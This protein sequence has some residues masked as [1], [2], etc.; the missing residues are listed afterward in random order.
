MAQQP[1]AAIAPYGQ[2]Q[3]RASLNTPQ[4]MRSRLRA[5]GQSRLFNA[6]ARRTRGSRSKPTRTSHRVVA[7][8]AAAQ[9]CAAAAA[10][11]T[12]SRNISAA[13]CA[14]A[15]RRASGTAGL[16]PRR[17]TATPRR[18]GRAAL[19]ARYRRQAAHRGVRPGRHHQH[20]HRRCRRQCQSAAGRHVPARGFT[21]Q[22]LSQSDHRAAQARLRARA[23]RQ[24]SRSRPT[25]RSSFSAKSPTPGQYPYVANMTAETAVAI[26]GGFAPRADK[27][28]VEAHPQRARPADARR[29]AA[30]LL[31]CAPATPSS[32]R[33]AGS[34]ASSSVQKSGGAEPSPDILATRREFRARGCRS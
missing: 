8:R 4:A 24:R 17:R 19:H 13:I 15:I 3:Y 26:A 21:T 32:S 23:A 16:T 22:Q 5:V 10:A 6:A 12:R 7:V 1:Y 25:G 29:R 9:L 27:S 30:Q 31:R 2:P 18:A 11:A 33:S 34:S 28:K 20:L 14:A